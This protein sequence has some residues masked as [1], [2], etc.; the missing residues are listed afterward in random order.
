MYKLELYFKADAEYNVNLEAIRQQIRLIAAKWETETEEL[1]VDQVSTEHVRRLIDDLRSIPPQ[2][3]GRIV[4]SRGKMLPLSGSRQLNVRNTP[5]LVL[6]ENARAIG[7]FPHLLGTAYFDLQSSLDRIWNSGPREY[8]QDRGLLENPIVQ[9]LA[10]DPALIEN[11]M[12]FVGSSVKLLA[13]SVDLV[14]QDRKG[15]DIVVEVETKARDDAVG[16][17]LRLARSYTEQAN[18]EFIRKMI[19][20]ADFEPGVLLACREAGIELFR[21]TFQRADS[22]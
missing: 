11:G 19:V 5:V 2:M 13:G 4:S 9:I 10:D 12:K 14:L 1:D 8:V 18:K 7:V 17:V 21:L 16:Q 20:C 3:R 15:T 6:R 22:S